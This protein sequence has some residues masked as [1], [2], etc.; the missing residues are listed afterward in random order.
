MADPSARKADKE[1]FYI[2]TAINY[3][4]GD[5]HMGHAYEAVTTDCIARFFRLAGRDVF[6][7]TGCDEHGLKIAQTAEKEN[8][9][10]I[11]IC[12]KY[13]AK[14]EEMAKRLNCSHDDFIRTTSDR[15]KELVRFVFERSLANGDIYKGKY[16]GWYNPREEAFVT[17]RE[18]EENQYKDPTSGNPLVRMDEDTYFFKMS[19]HQDWLVRHMREN[20]EFVQPEGR[21]QEM[22]GRL[23]EPMRDISISRCNFKWGI[24]LPND[25]DHVLYVWFDALTNYLSVITYQDEKSERRHYWPAALHVVGRD[26]TWFHTVI[27]P[28]I[29]HSADIPVF[30]SVFSHGFVLDDKGHKM[31]KSV[32]NVVD[33]FEM[34][35]RYGADPF[36]YFLLREGSFGKDMLFVEKH[37]T[38]RTDYELNEKLGNYVRR[39]AT[40]A[41]KYCG[42]KTP[43]ERDDARP[44]DVALLFKQLKE[45]FAEYDIHEASNH[46][47]NAAS[48]ANKY[49]TDAEPWKLKNHPE[50]Q[51]AI[52]GTCLEMLYV[53]AHV[54]EPF[55]PGTSQILYS[56]FHLEPKML[57]EISPE[58][59]NLSE[60]NPIDQGEILFQRLSEEAKAKV[61]AAKTG[62]VLKAKTVS[63]RVNES[64]TPEERKVALQSALDALETLHTTLSADAQGNADFLKT[65]SLLKQ[66]LQDYSPEHPFEGD[67]KDTLLQSNSDLRNV[68]AML[69]K[70]SD[71]S[72]LGIA[73]RVAPAVKI[74]CGAK[75][76]QPKKP[77]AKGK[78]AKG[79]TQAP[80]DLTV[81]PYD[82]RVGRIQ[83]ARKHPKADKLYVLSVDV[84]EE[85]PRQICAGLLKYYTAE[86]LE[87][88]RVVVMCNLKTAKLVGEKSH[89]MVLAASHGSVPD[90][91]AV[92]QPRDDVPV[93][94]P[95]RLSRPPLVV[96]SSLSYFLFLV[97]FC[98]VSSV[99]FPIV[100]AAGQTQASV[101]NISKSA[102]AKHTFT[103]GEDGFCCLDSAK[104]SAGSVPVVVDTT[105]D[106]LPAGAVVQ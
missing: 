6:F 31:S 22:L 91:V 37:L 51:R 14:F 102:M 23:E 32:G 63:T 99:C 10:P 87:G 11:A 61:E 59:N 73:G 60:G 71:K 84:G 45:C 44:I 58:Y 72:L 43:T 5:P 20:P 50:R 101:Q 1:P 69:K 34:L 53:L 80:V 19:R 94:T 35:D 68:F 26:I 29:L 25:P 65:V 47:V 89:G 13:A 7:S 48:A 2:S 104:V 54:F 3:T 12:N 24:P 28:C 85:A 67:A 106:P 96:I 82:L 103:V 9:E 21:R 39:V 4:N 90:S 57:D 100:L 88:K 62:V 95:G 40:L 41:H 52:V 86:E 55:I 15:H 49:L 33:P 46:I 105:K 8:L 36:R 64:S 97:R 92:I 16:E 76:P 78:S 66:L 79:A 18:A 38:H 30:K 42:G 81:C 75:P 74:L 98:S 17:D 77:T 83:S 27:W 93:G 56:R 70:M